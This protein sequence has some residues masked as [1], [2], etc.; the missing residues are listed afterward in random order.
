MSELPDQIEARL[1]ELP[2]GLRDHIER[3]REV[4]HELALRHRVNVTTADIGAAAHDL[5]RAVPRQELLAEADRLRLDI[6][7]VERHEPK[8]LHGPIAAAWLRE[9]CAHID[10]TILE[11]VAWH[12]TGRSGMTDTAKVVFLADKLDPH[13]VRRFPFLE[14]V[15][16]EAWHDLDTA[17]LEYL[18]RT[19]EHIMSQNLLIHTASLELRN[20]LIVRTAPPGR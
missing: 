5:A 12:T 18:N 14:R 17:I 7:I 19:I 6:G 15:A 4:A 20:E 10:T 16:L 2:Q 3:T 8:L 13:K 9:S 1:R 11:S